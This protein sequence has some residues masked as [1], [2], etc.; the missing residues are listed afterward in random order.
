MENQIH[1]FDDMDLEIYL[2]E[3]EH[4]IFAQEEECS[5]FELET[6]HTKEDINML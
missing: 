5:I 4:N 1:H 2:I 3:E 6:E